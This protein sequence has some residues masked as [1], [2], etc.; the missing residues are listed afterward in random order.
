MTPT[1]KEMLQAFFASDASYD[2]LFYVAVRTTHIF[3]K[4]SCSARKP[5]RENIEFFARAKDALFAG[6][7]ACLRCKPLETSTSPDW[8]QRL[9]ALTDGNVERVTAR[10]VISLGI[11]PARARRYFLRHFGMTFAEY[12][13]AQRLGGALRELGHG[14]TLDDAAYDSGFA[15]LSGF[16]DAFKKRF[17]RPPGRARQDRCIV[18][19]LLETPVGK[20]VAAASDQGVCLLEFTDRRMLERQLEI[21]QRRLG[22]IVPGNNEHLDQL[23]RELR[24]YFAGRRR[25][26]TVPLEAPGTPFQEQVWRTLCKIPFAETWSYDQLAQAAGQRKAV[27]AAGTANGMNRIAIIIPCHRV[28]RKSGELGGYGGGFWRKK[29]LL[30]HEHAA[31]RQLA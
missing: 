12:A 2:G 17:G 19:R 7:R 23:E 1:K 15:S 20:M 16:R 5:K 11:E 25:E 24:E 31:L 10:H 27:R 21:I 29:W 8:V 22:A 3:C 14:A 28:I 30:E 26:F 9:L 4:P 6:Y 13:R 18:S